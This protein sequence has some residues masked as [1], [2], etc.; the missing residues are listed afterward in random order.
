MGFLALLTS[1]PSCPQLRGTLPAHVTQILLMT[2]L[3]A[4]PVPMGIMGAGSEGHRKEGGEHS[5]EHLESFQQKA[6]SGFKFA[7]ARWGHLLP[8]MTLSFPHSPEQV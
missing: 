4:S 2:E 8:R 5:A 7:P 6:K 3:L 1:Q